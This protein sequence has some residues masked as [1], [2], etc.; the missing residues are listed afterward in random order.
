M[1]LRIRR[2]DAFKFFQNLNASK[3]LIIRRLQIALLIQFAFA[4][5]TD[6]NALCNNHIQHLK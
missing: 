1:R 3:Q 2:L 6:C 4:Q 5:T